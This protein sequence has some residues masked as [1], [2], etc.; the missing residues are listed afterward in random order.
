MSNFIEDVKD[1]LVATGAGLS[2]TFATNLFIAKEPTSPN[3]CVTLYPTSGYEPNP[4]YALDR[5]T[6]QVRVRGDVDGYIAAENKMVAI[7]NYLLGKGPTTINSS[8]IVG[9]WIDSDY[10]FLMYDVSNRPIFT[11]Q[12]RTYYQP[13]ATGNRI[14]LG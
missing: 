14:A 9:F 6:F 2:L 7:R 13:S 3:F 5:P 1:I 8:K 12:F 10:N 11:I 4:R